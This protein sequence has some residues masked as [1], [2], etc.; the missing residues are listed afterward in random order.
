MGGR[1]MPYSEYISVLHANPKVAAITRYGYNGFLY[2]DEGPQ[3][4]LEE[5]FLL[6]DD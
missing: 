1:Y 3:R 2:L 6:S 4:C 5:R